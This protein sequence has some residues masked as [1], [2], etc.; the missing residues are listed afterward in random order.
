MTLSLMVI[1]VHALFVMA[2]MEWLKET[3]QAIKDKSNV[4]KR[5][6]VVAAIAGVSMGSSTDWSGR[7]LTFEATF[8]AVV[9]LYALGLKPALSAIANKLG[10]T[11]S[12]EKLDELS[13]K[14]DAALGD[15]KKGVPTS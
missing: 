5:V 1:A 9:L 13:A 11:V 15:D 8:A 14:L 12:S 3:I 6:V 10:L 4:W 2:F 7:L